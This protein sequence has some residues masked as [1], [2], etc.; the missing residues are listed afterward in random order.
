MLQS[1]SKMNPGSGVG[2]LLN[3]FCHLLEQHGTNL[4]QIGKYISSTAAFYLP[5][6][7]Q[8]AAVKKKL[9]IHYKSNK[10]PKPQE[11]GDTIEAIL[12]TGHCRHGHDLGTLVGSLHK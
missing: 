8:S 4:D 12:R 2:D 11:P 3:Q 7:G 10:D 9:V 1:V 6:R 5:Q